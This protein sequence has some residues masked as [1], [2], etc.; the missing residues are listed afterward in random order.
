MKGKYLGK[1]HS[2]QSKENM[3]RAHLGKSNTPESNKK[4]SDA[5]RGSKKSPE[6]IERMKAAQKRKFKCLETGYVSSA[7]KLTVHQRRLG[8]DVS[9]RIEVKHETH[10]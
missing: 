9:K 8:I 10:H 3:R 2:A 5:L 7:S 4:R 6:T 1:K